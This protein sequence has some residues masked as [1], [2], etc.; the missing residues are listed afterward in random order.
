[1]GANI[2]DKKRACKQGKE[3]DLGK[4][5]MRLTYYTKSGGIYIYIKHF[6]QLL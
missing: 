5:E 4:L 2:N 3:R 6:V 1:M